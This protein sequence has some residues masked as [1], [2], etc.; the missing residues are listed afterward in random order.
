MA[1][2]DQ[3]TPTVDEVATAVAGSATIG[4]A[5]NIL[6]AAGWQC[7]VAG[8]RM[9]VGDGVCVRPVGQGAAG[10]RWLVYGIGDTSVIRVVCAD[11]SSG[12]PRANAGPPGSR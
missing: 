6:R 10:A 11:A 12:A 7:T 1:V 9:T 5:C 3:E 4:A 2:T 8:N